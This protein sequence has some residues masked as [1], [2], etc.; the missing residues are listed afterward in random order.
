V[1]R[2]TMVPDEQQYAAA[3]PFF[4]DHHLATLI[5]RFPLLSCLEQL[6]RDMSV[7]DLSDDLWQE[8][9]D[10]QC[11]DWEKFHLTKNALRCSRVCRRWKAGPC[12]SQRRFAS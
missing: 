3:R 12:I 10:S 5:A 2:D 4:S 9:F 8:I 1:W 6:R 7:V 11:E